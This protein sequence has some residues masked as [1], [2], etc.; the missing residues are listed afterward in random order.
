MDSTEGLICVAEVRSPAPMSMPTGD[1]VKAA[2]NV[3]G[4]AI[5]GIP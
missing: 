3:I 1:G 5:D 2:F 4:Q